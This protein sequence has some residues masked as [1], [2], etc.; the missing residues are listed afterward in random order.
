MSYDWGEFLELAKR[1]DASPGNPGPAEAASRSAASRA[2][3]AA[4]N[5]AVDFAS[6]EGFSAQASGEDHFRIQRHFQA[7]GSDEKRRKVALELERLLNLR[8]MADYQ[9]GLNRTP[10]SLSN[11]AVGH[12]TRILSLLS[13]LKPRPA[14]TH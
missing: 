6:Q 9:D 12:A 14:R 2:Y 5:V 8:R 10:V 13:E 7:T 4:F 11:H 3:Y 1:L